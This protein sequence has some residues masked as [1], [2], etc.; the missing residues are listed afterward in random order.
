MIV[1]VNYQCLYLNQY[2]NKTHTL[3]RKTITDSF[4]YASNS[5][6]FDNQSQSKPSRV[7]LGRFIEWWKCNTSVVA[8]AL[9][10]C[11][12]SGT[13]GSYTTS[14]IMR[15]YKTMLS[16]LCYNYYMYAY[17]LVLHIYVCMLTFKEF[18]LI[19]YLLVRI[20]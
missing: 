2:C 11:L 3:R 16:S 8:Q 17:T 7:H 13:R 9:M 14:G 6:N 18:K 1:E 4:V 19:P 5:Q 12:I 10:H 15:T 20:A